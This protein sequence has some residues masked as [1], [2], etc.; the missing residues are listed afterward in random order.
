L[1]VSIRPS[2]S[3]SSP[4]H[5]ISFL[6]ASKTSTSLGLLLIMFPVNIELFYMI[7]NKFKK[8]L[9]KKGALIAPYQE[10]N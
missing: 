8:Y 7:I 6:T 1:G 10:Y 2:L 9:I 3:G 5:R 4:A